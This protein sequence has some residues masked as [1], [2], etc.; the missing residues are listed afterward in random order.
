M[1]IKIIKDGKEL[2]AT[3]QDNSTSKDFYAL[4]PLTLKTD[5]FDSCEKTATLPKK[6]SINGAPK[7]YEGR[8]GDITYYAPWGNLAIFYSFPSAG[9]A[10]GLVYMGRIE[11]DIS[12][13]T[14]GSNQIRIEK[15]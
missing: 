7:G 5:D 15:L 6:L 9:Y 2:K 10:S 8:S 12:V 13:L 1:K 3:L 4:L 14:T 11:G